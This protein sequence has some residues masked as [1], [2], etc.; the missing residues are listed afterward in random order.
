MDER[1]RVKFSSRQA[2]VQLL[3][4]DMF[5]PFDLE[6]FRL[7]STTLSNVEPFVGERTAHAAKYSAIRKV[8][9]RR[10]HYAPRR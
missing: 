6:R 4:I 10:L 2:P 8:P 3:V 5:S 7:F 1:D 9:N